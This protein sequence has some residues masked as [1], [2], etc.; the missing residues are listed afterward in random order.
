MKPQERLEQLKQILKKEIL[1]KKYLK[2]KEYDRILLEFG[3]ETYS[4]RIPYFYKMKEI[5]RLKKAKNYDL[6]RKKYGEKEYQKYISFVLKQDVLIE[7]G[8][9]HLANKHQ[10]SYLARKF[11]TQ[12]IPE[13]TKVLLVSSTILMCIA[14]LFSEVMTKDIIEENK[15]EYATEI[16]LYNENAAAYA[17]EIKAL[18]E[19]N[20]YTDLDIFMKV[21]YDMWDNIE[22][23]G[24]PTIDATG[25][26]RLD[27]QNGVGVCRHMADDVAYKLNEINPDYNARTLCVYLKTD[28]ACQIA[29]IEQ[30][31]APTTESE[32]IVSTPEEDSIDTTKVFG[33]HSVTLV[34]VN[35]ITLILDPTNPMIGVLK[36]GKIHIL[37]PHT[38][39]F[40][41]E[42]VYLGNA[43]MTGIDTYEYELRKIPSFL[44]QESLEE[45]NNMYGLEAQNASIEK[46]TNVSK[47]NTIN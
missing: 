4:K 25:Y 29:N 36:D 11:V 2:Q 41:Y 3:S 24:E 45:L 15:T 30:K 9:V 46:I 31:F 12:T 16:S 47:T 21:M 43:L 22:G 19:E 35:D 13:T 1:I 23:Y 44:V 7:T 38:E 37:N 14:P 6:I 39:N 33:N 42:D 20:N 32:E 26:L 40:G 18:A 17:T 10:I 28:G 27:M 34:D 5:K 8:N